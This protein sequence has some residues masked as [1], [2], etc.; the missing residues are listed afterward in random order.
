[1]LTAGK[2]SRI[3]QIMEEMEQEFQAL[4][5]KLSL[6]Q[7]DQRD[8]FFAHILGGEYFAS[9][10]E[11]LAVGRSIGVE[12]SNA[13][14]IV[15]MAKVE[16][17]GELFQQGGMDQ[18]DLNFI[19]R[20]TL[21]N[22]FSGKT[23]AADVQGK[24]VAIINLEQM[25]EIGFRGIIQ[26]TSHMLEV[27]E[28]E[29]GITITV[30]FSRVYDS[31]LQL[32]QAMRDV[33][34]I[35]EYLQLM[36]EDRPITTYDELRHP[37]MTRSNTSFIDLETRLLGCIRAADFAGMRLVMHELIGNEFGESKPTVD[38]FRFRI[39]GV[40]NTLL[41]LMN[42]IRSVVGDEI[43]A[44]IDPGPRLT[45]AETLDEIVNVMDDII[46]RLEQHTN[47][48]YQPTVP[49]WV[50]KVYEYVEEN[51]RDPNVTVSS[52][53]DQF[54]LTPTYC[55]KVFREYYNLRLFDCIQLKRLNAAKTLLPTEM[56]LKDIADI[57]GF[58]NALTM[59]RAFK[60]Y[61]G[62]APNKIREQ[63]KK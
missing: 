61:E 38:T 13:S 55:S 46:L 14:Y 48:K 26:D 15:L 28:T 31:L 58:S 25:P 42:D 52:I 41:Y 30:A 21:E 63:L 33:N 53:A 47:Q 49:A 50:H 32:P 3:Q 60:R 12:F 9:E 59:S 62:V 45:S 35:F 4:Q 2:P 23:N 18:K 54:S 37:H 1:M 51:F 44:E 5:Q 39:Y 40:V 43:I 29:F 22:G 27:L 16:S 20:N 19:L 34:L 6:A 24:M 10:Q 7:C 8:L 56:N 57:V 36:G 11:L 17:W